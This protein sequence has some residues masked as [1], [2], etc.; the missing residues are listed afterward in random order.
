MSDTTGF[1]LNVSSSLQPLTVC[2]MALAFKRAIAEAEKAIE[3]ANKSITEWY[4]P[5]ITPALIIDYDSAK[6]VEGVSTQ[7]PNKAEL[8]KSITIV[9]W[10][11]DN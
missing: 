1:P 11:K 9:N 10:V 6:A 4:K 3:G 2:T 5:P 7:N 8:P